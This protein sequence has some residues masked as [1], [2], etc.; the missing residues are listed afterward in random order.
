MPDFR[1]DYPLQIAVGSILF[2]TNRYRP[3]DVALYEPGD[4]RT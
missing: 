2:L 3:A 1:G 4:Q